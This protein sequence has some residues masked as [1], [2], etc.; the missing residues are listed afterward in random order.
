MVIYIPIMG[1]GE[2]ILSGADI[3][4]R[5]QSVTYQLKYDCYANEIVVLAKES[6]FGG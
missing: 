3:L 1:F 6:I 2:N 4:Q 5:Y